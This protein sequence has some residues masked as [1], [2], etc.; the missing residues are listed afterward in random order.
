MGYGPGKSVSFE[1]YH[2]IP[3]GWEVDV[4]LEAYERMQG[5]FDIT[6]HQVQ[7]DAA[8]WFFYRQ[9]L[10]N[11]ADGVRANDQPCVEL[12]IRFIEARVVVS[13]S[14]Y[15][16]SILARRLRKAGLSEEQKSRLSTHFLGLLRSGTRCHEFADYLRL[17]RVFVTARD[18]AE[19]QALPAGSGRDQANFASFALARLAPEKTRTPRDKKGERKRL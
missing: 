2:R 12:A 7:H 15:M 3:R 8:P 11:I 14:G 4:V 1:E 17:W 9:L 6:P 10:L 16:R 5:R 18:V 19:L 13:Y